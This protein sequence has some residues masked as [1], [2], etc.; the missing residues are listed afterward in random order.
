LGASERSIRDSW[1]RCARRPRYRARGTGVKAKPLHL[2]VC[3]VPR[4]QYLVDLPIGTIHA[5]PT[6]A[7][8]W[9]T[10]RRRLSTPSVPLSTQARWFLH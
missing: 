2:V 1:Q 4:S 8:L 3:N 9:S 5:P 6:A 10:L 7:A